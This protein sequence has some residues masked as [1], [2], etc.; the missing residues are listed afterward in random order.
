MTCNGEH[1]LCMKS[2][3][4]EVRIMMSMYLC[5]VQPCVRVEGARARAFY[6]I[7]YVVDRTLLKVMY[8]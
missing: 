7:R 3:E 5:L 2:C 1:T 8:L 4:E 6:R